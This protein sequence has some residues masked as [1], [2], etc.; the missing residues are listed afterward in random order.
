MS[1]HPY[2][3]PSALE[4][5]ETSKIVS[6]ILLPHK[7]MVWLSLEGAFVHGLEDE[8]PAG[9]IC[10]MFCIRMASILTGLNTR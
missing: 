8:F 1:F 4:G 2:E 9:M 7:Q 10:Y 6:R 5:A 3:V